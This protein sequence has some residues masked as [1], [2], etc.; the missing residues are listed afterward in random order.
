[1]YFKIDF[2]I[3]FK[4]LISDC[5]SSHLSMVEELSVECFEKLLEREKIKMI[6][7]CQ[8]SAF[9]PHTISPIHGIACLVQMWEAKLRRMAA[10][11]PDMI[12]VTLPPHQLCFD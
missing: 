6:S 2:K 9:F 5:R 1:M 7:V 8:V 12:Q 4:I 3:D 11:I 10:E